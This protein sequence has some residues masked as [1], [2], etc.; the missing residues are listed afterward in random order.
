[1]GLRFSQIA[2]QFW[3]HKIIKPRSGQNTVG[4]ND[5]RKYYHRCKDGWPLPG[6]VKW[7]PPDFRYKVVR[8]IVIDMNKID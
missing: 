2:I 1:M 5:V 4:V 3:K 7:R 6:G 8:P